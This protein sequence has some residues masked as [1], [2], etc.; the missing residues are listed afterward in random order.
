VAA[1]AP[2][3]QCSSDCPARHIGGYAAPLGTTGTFAPL[4]CPWLKRPP[5][6]EQPLVTP[7]I[8]GSCQPCHCPAVHLRSATQTTMLPSTTSTTSSIRLPG[9]A[10]AGGRGRS[11]R[12]CCCSTVAVP[13]VVGWLRGLAGSNSE[14]S[15][16][17]SLGLNS[18][19]GSSGRGTCKTCK[20]LYHLLPPAAGRCFCTLV[21]AQ[22]GQGVAVA[23]SRHGCCC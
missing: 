4:H 16:T 20:N 5:I 3:A 22:G 13:T 11:R 23:P 9:D 10:S 8:A 21:Y 12:G 19:P 14:V 17:C 15:Q 2:A 18:R 6:S 1:L 7:A